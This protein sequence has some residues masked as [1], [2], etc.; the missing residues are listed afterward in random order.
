MQSHRLSWV[1]GIA[2]VG[3]LGAIYAIASTILLNSFVLVEQRQVE[4]DL[5]QADAVNNEL[6]VLAIRF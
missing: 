4:G 3:S 2:L 5:A 6:N 1:I